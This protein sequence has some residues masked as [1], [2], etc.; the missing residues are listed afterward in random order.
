MHASC[1]KS[2]RLWTRLQQR[3]PSATHRLLCMENREWDTWGRMKGH[4][5]PRLHG[6][7]HTFYREVD[8]AHHP[9]AAACWTWYALLVAFCGAGRAAASPGQNIP[10]QNTS[11]LWHVPRPRPGRS[12]HP[13]SACSRP[14]A[15]CTSCGIFWSEEGVRLAQKMQVGLLYA[16]P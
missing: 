7:V 16:C 3:Q 1:F 10:V 8:S 6:C 13:V 14:A 2:A 15:A 5:R 12:I 11:Y 9:H 4:D